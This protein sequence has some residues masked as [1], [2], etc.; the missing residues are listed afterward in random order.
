MGR[1]VALLR[2]AVPAVAGLPAE[3]RA[4]PLGDGIEPA[5]VV[6]QSEAGVLRIRAQGQASM[7][8]RNLPALAAGR[9][10]LLRWQWQVSGAL[11]TARLDRKDGDDA[12]ARVLVG[13]AF[14]PEK[15]T[16]FERLA[17]DRQSRKS[18][19]VPG[20]ALCYVWAG[21]E[22]IGTLLDNPYNERVRVIVLVSGS[23]YA[24]SWQAVERDLWADYQLAFGEAP[25][26]LEGV[27]LMVDS[28]QTGEGV[29]GSFRGLSLSSAE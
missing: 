29:E 18:P 7:L 9:R 12:A 16:L 24:G 14:E 4:V 5:D 3:W 23:D 1:Q 27:A 15:A 8:A 6:W 26:P 13:F 10:L 17:H 28:D 19:F 11:Q 22:E 25:P 21:H 20:T 2:E